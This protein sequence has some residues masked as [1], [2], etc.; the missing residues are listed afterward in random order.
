MD[1]DGNDGDFP[2]PNQ[3]YNANP[4]NTALSQ[5]NRPSLSQMNRLEESFFSSSYSSSP[6]STFRHG[7]GS[8]LSDYPASEWGGSL[9]DDASSC[10]TNKSSLSQVNRP[11]NSL[12]GSSFGHNLPRDIPVML[13]LSP[14]SAGSTFRYIYLAIDEHIHQEPLLAFFNNAGWAVHILP[15][16][17]YDIFLRSNLI[18]TCNTLFITNLPPHIL[19]AGCCLLENNKSLTDTAP[20]LSW[21]PDFPSSP[22]FFGTSRT[23]P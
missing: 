7:E 6:S 4:N 13:R 10:S 22:T 3:V 2:H 8:N 14:D 1:P 21:L 16:P 20:N 12:G 19:P 11:S 17:D 23:V 5:A 15:C 18:G 9:V